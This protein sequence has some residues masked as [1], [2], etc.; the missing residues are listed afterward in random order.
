MQNY[1]LNDICHKLVN[2]DTGVVSCSMEGYVLHTL[3]YFKFTQMN[4][5]C[6]SY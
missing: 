5:A 3:Q 4:V 2:C 6:A 1:V